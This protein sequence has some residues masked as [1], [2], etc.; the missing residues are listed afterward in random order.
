MHANWLVNADGASA[1]DL[2]ALIELV[3]HE[4]AQKFGITLELEVKVV[5]EDVENAN[6]RETSR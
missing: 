4:V 2:L 5:G 6:P 1:R 3:R